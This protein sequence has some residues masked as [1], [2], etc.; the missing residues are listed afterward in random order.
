MDKLVSAS[1]STRDIFA[2]EN[3]AFSRLKPTYHSFW[4]IIRSQKPYKRLGKAGPTQNVLY[5]C[6]YIFACSSNPGLCIYISF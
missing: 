6:P 5:K 1:G 3:L 2:M 4:D